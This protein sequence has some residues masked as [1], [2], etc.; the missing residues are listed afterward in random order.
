[1]VEQ[2]IEVVEVAGVVI[3]V[4]EVVVEADLSP[5]VHQFL[6][7]SGQHSGLEG[8]VRQFWQRS[9]ALGCA[10]LLLPGE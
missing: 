10:L 9:L 4:V 7:L 1:M 8:G 5:A 3:E 2:V 6:D